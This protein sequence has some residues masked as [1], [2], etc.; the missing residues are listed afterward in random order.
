MNLS[1]VN[2]YIVK[3]HVSYEFRLSSM[4]NKSE[5]FTGFMKQWLFH[6][7]PQV[8]LLVDTAQKKH[9]AP[10]NHHDIHL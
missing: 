6:A 8:V 2:L 1:C 9:Y 7:S 10:G 4:Q 3:Y 5:Q